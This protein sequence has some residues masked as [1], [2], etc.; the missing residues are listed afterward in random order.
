MS[1]LKQGLPQ[2]IAQDM[3]NLKG[4]HGDLL[5]A[6]QGMIVIPELEDYRF[7]VTAFP[8]VYATASDP[9]VT[10]VGGGGDVITPSIPKTSFEG[11]LTI[12]ETERGAVNELAEFILNC[13]GGQIPKIDLY[14]GHLH[15]YTMVKEYHNVAIRFETSDLDTDSKSEVVKVSAPITFNYF[16]QH[17]KIGTNGTVK[18]G[19]ANMGKSDLLSRVENTLSTIRRTTNAVGSITN[20]IKQLGSLF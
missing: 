8:N 13:Q 17:A 15:Q 2:L 5:L 7:L 16:G 12:L 20:G 1:I 18:S 11:N 19:Q 6:C 3:A 14:I 4:V 9:A 10:A